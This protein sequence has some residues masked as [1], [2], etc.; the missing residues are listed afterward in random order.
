M[1]PSKWQRQSPQEPTSEEPATKLAIQ[2][3]LQ[4]SVF[5]FY[6][7]KLIAWRGFLFRVAKCHEFGG[8][9]R[10]KKLEG[11]GKKSGRTYTFATSSIV[12]TF[13]NSVS[14]LGVGG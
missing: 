13:G 7:V 4:M 9:I 5:L 1:E 3:C 14:F 11:W 10:V 6:V 2:E 12:L 8:Y